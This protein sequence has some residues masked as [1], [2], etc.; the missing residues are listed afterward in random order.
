VRH[1]VESRIFTGNFYDLL[2]IGTEGDEGQSAEDVLR[3][4]DEKLAAMGIDPLVR[5]AIDTYRKK[6]FGTADPLLPRSVPPKQP[7]APAAPGKIIPGT[8]PQDVP[9]S[10]EQAKA[11]VAQAI[12]PAAAAPGHRTLLCEKC[13][14]AVSEQQVKLSRLL[15]GMTL[16]KKCL[17]VGA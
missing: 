9:S 15:R 17:E 7:Q 14:E 16:C 8:P 4:H 3:I 12:K 13:G 2:V 11:A 6:H 1:S 10:A 5:G